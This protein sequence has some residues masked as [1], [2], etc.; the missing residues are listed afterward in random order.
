[1]YVS[2]HFGNFGKIERLIQVH[3]QCIRQKYIFIFSKNMVS[4]YLAD[5]DDKHAHYTLTLMI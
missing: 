5:I 1:M 3:L 4:L 2:F